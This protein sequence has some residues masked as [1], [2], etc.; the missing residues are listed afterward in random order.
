MDIIKRQSSFL[1][2]VIKPGEI[3][4]KLGQIHID[5]AK[6]HLGPCNWSFSMKL[7]T[8]SKQEPLAYE[9]VSPNE[10]LVTGTATITKPLWCPCPRGLAFV[11]G[12]L[13]QLLLKG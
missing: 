6:P 11:R 1:T 4:F 7:G 9:N 5:P 13:P 2:S 3:N 8:L 12:T 10:A